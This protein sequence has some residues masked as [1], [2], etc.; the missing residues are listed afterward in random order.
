MR[1]QRLVAAGNRLGL[2]NATAGEGGGWD[3][4]GPP[5]VPGFV[6]LYVPFESGT[7]YWDGLPLVAGHESDALPK[8]ESL[9]THPW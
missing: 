5:T 1:P 4:T 3:V 6:V 7:L 9:R 2:V 8:C